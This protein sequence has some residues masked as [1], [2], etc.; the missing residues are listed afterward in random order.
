MAQ[1]TTRE[2]WYPRYYYVL[3]NKTSGKKYIGQTTQPITKYLGSGVH[4]KPHCEKHGG[5]NK[6]NIKI[7]EKVFCNNR[8]EAE[9]WLNIK[10]TQLGEYWVGNEYL[11]MVPE[12]TENNPRC[13][14]HINIMRMK[15][16]IH[17]WSKENITEKVRL[18]QSRSWFGTKKHKESIIEKYGVDNIMKVPEIAKKSG[19]KQSITKK[20]RNTAKNGNN[21][22]AKSIRVNGILF[23]TMKEASQ[24]FCISMHYLRKYMNKERD[25]NLDIEILKRRTVRYGKSNQ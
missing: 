2:E 9:K 11:N 15:K 1:P 25:I 6:D 24:Y 18:A 4:W 13:G 14:P 12:T 10:E 21:G 19:E 8:F 16:G 3:E 22:N 17:P 20:I 7:I 5:Y 23:D